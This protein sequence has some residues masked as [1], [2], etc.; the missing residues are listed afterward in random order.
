[1]VREAHLVQTDG[2]LVPNDDGWFVLNAREAE[3]WTLAT[4]GGALCDFEGEPRFQQLGINLTRLE[5]AS[6]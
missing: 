1:M 4:G 5:P 2:A 6:R 3:W